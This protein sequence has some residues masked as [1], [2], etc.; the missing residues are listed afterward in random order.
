VSR[1]SPIIARRKRADGDKSNNPRNT[2]STRRYARRQKKV[3]SSPCTVSGATRELC[4]RDCRRLATLRF[5]SFCVTTDS[6]GQLYQEIGICTFRSR[7]DVGRTSCKPHSLFGRF[8]CT[9]R[10]R[11]RY[12]CFRLSLLTI[13]FP[14]H[15]V[16]TLLQR[17][18]ASLQQS[19]IQQH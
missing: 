18:R 10:L 2:V 13:S 15:H 8:G 5:F 12:S 17:R 4:I 16:E 7:H 9:N 14:R 6:L 3:S 19:C 11:N 1:N